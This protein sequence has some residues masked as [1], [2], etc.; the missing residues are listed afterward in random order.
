MFKIQFSSFQFQLSENQ[1]SFFRYFVDRLNG[2]AYTEF[3][4]IKI[5][6][7]LMKQ[8]ENKTT[9]IEKVLKVMMAFTSDAD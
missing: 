4:L 1:E 8:S 7:F 9:A 6:F 3:Y 5:E 2:L